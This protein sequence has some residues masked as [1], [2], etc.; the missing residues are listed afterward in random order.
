MLTCLRTCSRM[1][2]TVRLRP[3]RSTTLRRTSQHTSKRS[4]TRST[5]QHGTASWEETLA[6]TSL[7]RR[8]TSSTSTWARWRSSCSNPAEGLVARVECSFPTWTKMH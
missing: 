1:Q 4:L 8:S 7:T 5:T 3:W 6:A 2:L